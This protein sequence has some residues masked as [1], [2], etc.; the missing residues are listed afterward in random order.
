MASVVLASDVAIVLASD[1]AIAP[2][3]VYGYLA[4]GS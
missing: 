1:V 3:H 2:N 4:M